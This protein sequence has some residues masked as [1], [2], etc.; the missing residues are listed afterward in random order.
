MK[1]FSAFLAFLLA[2][3]SSGAAEDTS[4]STLDEEWKA[5]VQ[6]NYDEFIAEVDGDSSKIPLIVST[7]QHGAIDPKSEYY[8][9]INSIVDWTKVSKIINLGDT[10]KELFNV[11][12]LLS[13]RV[14]TM[15]LPD[16]KRI[17]VVGNHDRFFLPVGAPVDLFFFPN[18]EN[19]I[20]I[21][22]KAFTVKDEEFNVRYL[23]LDTKYFPWNSN[24]GALYT[25]DADYLVRELSKNDPS[26]IILLSHPYIFNDAIIS[27]TGRVFT[28]SD[29]YIGLKREGSEA[30]QS[31]LDMLTA[32]KNKTSG[33][34]VD[35]LGIKHPYDFTN[36]QG[37]FL[38]SL[39]G[40]HHTEGYETK[41]GITE[42][43][44]QSMT[45]DNANNTEPGVFYFAYIDRDA[46]TF[47]CWKN[48]E[49]YDAWEISIA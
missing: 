41:D 27:R 44:F 8:Q 1:L 5:T 31:F 40:H 3:F 10:V 17:E 33:V 37:E 2:F 42:F 45:L 23:A 25:A 38:M 14:A 35:S 4:F 19:S 28:G 26:D 12:D 39:H 13:Y 49:G 7:D 6:A 18:D 48:Y 24:N 30:K 32:R 47:K 20:A 43:L 29:Y 11:G 15:C 22:R 21:D 16:E 36:C 9:Y 34:L 46:K